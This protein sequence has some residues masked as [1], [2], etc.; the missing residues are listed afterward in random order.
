MSFIEDDIN[1]VCGNI[2]KEYFYDNGKKYYNYYVDCS[3]CNT[4]IFIEFG[5]NGKRCSTV[6]KN[7]G[8]KNT[9]GKWVCP[10]CIK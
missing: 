6:L 9:G 10:N 3:I 8:W 1:S 5:K 2:Y 4:E 7:L